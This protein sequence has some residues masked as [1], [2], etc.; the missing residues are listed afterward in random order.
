MCWAIKIG[1]NPKDYHKIAEEDKVVYSVGK[2]A[3]CG[4]FEP[5]STFPILYYKEKFTE[6]SELNMKEDDT[7]IWINEGYYS[8]SENCSYSISDWLLTVYS[9][10][11][12]GQG[13]NNYGLRNDEVK[14][15]AVG[16]F[17][18]P[19]GAEYYEN[20]DGEIVSSQFMYTGEYA[21]YGELTKNG[22]EQFKDLYINNR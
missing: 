22:F 6:Y 7:S 13:I 14:T 5:F 8:F 3:C 15:I 21:S 10:E 9:A 17:N 18:I 1:K 19:K 4:I 12:C 2:F 11:K 20:E 16:K